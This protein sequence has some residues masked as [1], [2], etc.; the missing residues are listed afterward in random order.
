M[1]NTLISVIVPVYNAEKY[2]R[3]CIESILSQTYTHFELLL[4]NDGSKDSSPQVC[5]EY[6]S[7]DE[8][9]RV[10]HQE[11]AGVSAARNKGLDNAQ[12]EYICFVDADDTVNED[13][14]SLMSAAMKE[15]IDIVHCGR[16]KFNKDEKRKQEYT[17]K[18]I[19]LNQIESKKKF[20][21][22]RAFLGS[23]WAKLF[24]T[25]I[26]KKH[27]LRFKEYSYAEDQLFVYEY[28]SFIILLC[29]IKEKLYNY[30]DNEDSAMNMDRKN[31]SFNYEHY[32]DS[33]SVFRQIHKHIS[34]TCD[35]KMER[36]ARGRLYVIYSTHL[37]FYLKYN[38]ADCEVKDTL[39]DG[40]R[41]TF[42]PY[43]LFYPKTI[44]QSA[45]GLLV[46]LFPIIS[47][48]LILRIWKKL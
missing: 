36:L 48:L 16:T 45:K 20:L 3:E 19:I 34:N 9:I 15:K 18:I 31:K 1:E 2:L 33:L 11:N 27:N 37:L 7:R 24:K 47:T 12:G 44:W 39:T 30:R 8:R 42:L 26:I 29:N 14:I 41:L 25:K 38:A 17:G 43:L 6:A 28:L 5:N 35:R 21:D 40:I 22:G 10:F 23:V 13:F 4:I 32:K 46:F